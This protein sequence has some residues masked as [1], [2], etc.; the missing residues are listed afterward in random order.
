MG[1]LV[2]ALVL[3]GSA[4]ALRFAGLG[5]EAQAPAIDPGLGTPVRVTPVLDTSK[6]SRGS[7]PKAWRANPR[8]RPPRKTTSTETPTHAT[9]TEPIAEAPRPRTTTSTPQAPRKSASSLPGVLPEVSDEPAVEAQ[10]E[11][12]A[13]PVRQLPSAVDESDDVDRSDASED[14]EAEGR[15]AGDPNALEE[16]AIGIYRGQLSAWFRRGFEVHGTGLSDAELTRLRGRTRVEISGD[17][18]I[19][20]FTITPSGN[21]AFDDAVRRHLEALRDATVPAPPDEYPGAA[22]KVLNVTFQCAASAC[23]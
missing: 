22:Q 14:D 20:D 17:L 12:E 11:A 21:K 2:A 23:D 15:R 7:M 5:K 9:A 4:I 16:R 3:L 10:P 1:L 19:I 8:P 18:S 6:G 13:D